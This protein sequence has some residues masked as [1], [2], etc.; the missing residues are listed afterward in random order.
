MAL[1][2]LCLLSFLKLNKT[3]TVKTIQLKLL[4][5]INCLLFLLLTLSAIHF[6]HTEHYTTPLQSTTLR[7]QVF[8]VTKVPFLVNSSLLRV[9]MSS[10]ESEGAFWAK[11]KG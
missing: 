3:A 8:D 4:L 5:C 10:Q 9:N 7:S 2:K 11:G 6:G 1:E